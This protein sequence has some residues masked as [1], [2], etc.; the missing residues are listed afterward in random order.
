MYTAFLL[1]S[2]D[3][4]NSNIFSFSF[5]TFADTIVGTANAKTDV[6]LRN[7]HQNIRDF[8]LLPTLNMNIMY[9]SCEIFSIFDV[10]EQPRAKKI[11][12]IRA[13]CQCASWRTIF[14]P[15]IN[16]L[17]FLSCNLGILFKSRS[18]C[19]YRFFFFFCFGHFVRHHWW[20]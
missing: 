14:G 10:T 6:A 11:I 2:N 18:D 19:R 15:Q 8:S 5:S 12:Y 3:H 20:D 13:N 1:G 7:M 9:S 4:N 17:C 16:L